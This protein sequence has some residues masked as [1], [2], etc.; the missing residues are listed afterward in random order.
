MVEIVVA[1]DLTS[2]QRRPAQP[3]MM[4]AWLSSSLKIAVAFAVSPAPTFPRRRP[5][6]SQRRDHRGIGL[7]AA[8]EKQRGLAP[9]KAASFSSTARVMSRVPVTRREAGAPAPW[10]C[11]HSAAR[12]RHQRVLG[13]AQVVVGRGVDQGAAARVAQYAVRPGDRPQPAPAM[14]GIERGELLLQQGVQRR[15]HQRASARSA[16]TLCTAAVSVASRR[17]A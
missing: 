8:G 14:D 16:S 5:D 17:R 13:E 9:L 4:L 15:R 11:A 1:E 2:S 3:W 12:C 7:E 6:A 10:R